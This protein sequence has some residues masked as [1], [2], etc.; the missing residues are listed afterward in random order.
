MW[1]CGGKEVVVVDVVG[2]K[3]TKVGVWAKVGG[4]ATS[5]KTSWVWARDLATRLW[6][7]MHGIC[8]ICGVLFGYGVDVAGL[9]VA[10]GYF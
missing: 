6:A 4:M 10:W 2:V 7:S 8:G 5:H 3:E 1:F 9:G